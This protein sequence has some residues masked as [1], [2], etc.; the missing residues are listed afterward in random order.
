MNDTLKTL[1]A[2]LKTAVAT[3]EKLDVEAIPGLVAARLL[4]SIEKTRADLL[5]AKD[6]V[7][8]ASPD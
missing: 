2:D 4:L 6:A 7:V 8:A 5:L 1:L 3:V